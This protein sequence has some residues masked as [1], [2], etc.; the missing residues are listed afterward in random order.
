[1][2]L[3]FLNPLHTKI[4]VANRAM[5]RFRRGDSM[6]VV[7]AYRPTGIMGLIVS[8]RERIGSFGYRGGAEPEPDAKV[9]KEDPHGAS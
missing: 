1:M 3:R 6:L 5:I 8:N 7:V 4:A 2:V 9:V